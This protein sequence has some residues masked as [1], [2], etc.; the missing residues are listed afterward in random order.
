M[1]F[2]YK[3]T[4]P[5]DFIVMQTRDFMVNVFENHAFS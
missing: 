3:Y 4:R 5:T 1:S 2:I